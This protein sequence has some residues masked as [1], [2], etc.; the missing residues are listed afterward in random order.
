MI[1]AR[2]S[3]IIPTLNEERNIGPLLM[4]LED[5]PGVE[6]V[7]SDGGSTDKTPQI[8]SE[9]ATRFLSG[10]SGRG[11]QLNAGAEAASGEVLFFLHA[12]S[13][14]DATVFDSIRA[15]LNNGWRWGCCSLS[16]DEERWFFHL[17]ALASRLRAA[18]FGSCYGDQGIF[19]ER[20]LFFQVEGFPDLPIMEDLCLSKKLRNYCPVTVLPDKIITSSRRFKQGG[21]FKVVLKMQMIKLLFAFG[22]PAQRLER[23][24]R[25]NEE[26]I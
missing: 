9:Y 22:V 12:D 19:C 10:R 23:F 15:A 16:F 17:V 20:N 3:V 13:L 6:V 4:Q 7:V 21:L 5:Q 24:Y 2:V 25:P 14:V 8:C 18:L 26:G 11:R 1:K